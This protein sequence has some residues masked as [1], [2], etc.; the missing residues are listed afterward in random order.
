[1]NNTTIPASV[2]ASLSFDFRGQRFTPSVRVDLHAMMVKKQPI[3]HLYDLLGASIGLD[4]YRHEYDVMVMNDIIFSEPAGLACD[5]V[6]NG[7]LDFDAFSRAWQQQQTLTA[8][9]PIA[10][11]HL[12]IDNLDQHPDIR[13]ALIESYQAGQKNNQHREQ[14]QSFTGF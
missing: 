11:K 8:I 2:T 14:F 4:A 13:N 9:A 3:S 12:N 6:N 7:Q 5:F 1:M 10:R